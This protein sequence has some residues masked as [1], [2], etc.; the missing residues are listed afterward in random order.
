MRTEKPGTAGKHSTLSHGRE[1]RPS[2][3]VAGE[4]F[5]S[6]LAGEVSQELETAIAV[7]AD[8]AARCPY[9]MGALCSFLDHVLGPWIEV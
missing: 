3:F 2:R 5:F 7:S 6:P 4:K 1:L 9:Q 8:R